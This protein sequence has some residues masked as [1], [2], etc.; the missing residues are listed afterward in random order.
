[1]D[2][3]CAA[4]HMRLVGGLRLQWLGRRGKGL[5]CI[6]IASEELGA[7]AVIALRAGVLAAKRK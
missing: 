3:E 1:V 6:V 4:G 7:Q 5:A 2:E